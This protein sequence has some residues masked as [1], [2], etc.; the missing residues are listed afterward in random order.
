VCSPRRTNNWTTDD[1]DYE[2][3]RID[4]QT[5]FRPPRPHRRNHGM[6]NNLSIKKACA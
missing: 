5:L 2:T 6:D 3:I 1:R 4:M